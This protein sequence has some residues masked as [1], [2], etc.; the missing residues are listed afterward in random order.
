MRI[1]LA[2]LA[3]AAAV[4]AVTVHASDR[5]G[6]YALVDRVVFEPNA[7]NPERVQIWGAFAVAKRNDNNYYDAVQR[8]Y[9]YFSGADR[10]SRNEWNDLKALAGTKKIAAFSSRFGQSLRVRGENEKPASP[11]R[12]VLGTGVQTIQSDRDYAPIKDLASHLTR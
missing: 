9:L 1:T 4:T 8:G 6:V 3:L 7:E 11:D 10:L 5:V 2:A 12:Y